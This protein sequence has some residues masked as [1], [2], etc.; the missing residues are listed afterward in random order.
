MNREDLEHIIRAAADVTDEYEFI[1]VGSQSILGAIPYPPEVFKMSAEADIYPRGAEEK[2]TLIDG[3]IGEG[4][5]FHST[6]GFY[7]Q[8]VD[9]KTATLPLGWEDRLHR[10][11]TA[12]TNDRLGLCLDV[13]DLFMSKAAANREKDREFNMALLLHGYVQPAA[14]IKMVDA[15]HRL[16]EVEKKSMRARIRRWVKALQEQGHEIPTA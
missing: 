13:I 11:Q 2:S 14:A 6:Y 8:G 9:S 10:V 5:E 16:S 4:S 3:A 12:G 15:M 7:A 1:I